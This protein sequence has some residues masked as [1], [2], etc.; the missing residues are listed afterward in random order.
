M[1]EQHNCHVDPIEKPLDKE[2]LKTAMAAY[3]GVSGMGCQNCAAR[4]RNGLVG[5]EGVLLSDVF[6]ERNVAVA[7][8]DPELVSVEDLLTAVT[9]AGNDGRHNYAAQLL[10]EVPALD[11]VILDE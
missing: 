11:A 7:A 4:V 10:K 5:L 8:Y 6:L 2:A 9:A 1:S 3:L